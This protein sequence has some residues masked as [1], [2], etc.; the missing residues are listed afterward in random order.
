MEEFECKGIWWL[1]DDI[2]VHLYG[3]L[4]YSPEVGANLELQGSF[5]TIAESNKNNKAIKAINKDFLLRPTIILGKTVDGKFITLYKCIQTSLTQHF[6]GLAVSLFYAY[7]VF[8]GCHFSREA[9]IVFKSLSINYSNLDDW[10]RVSGFEENTV[11]DNNGQLDKIEIS[12]T[13][14]RIIEAKIDKFNITISFYLDYK[15]KMYREYH[16][17]QMT[18][19][20]MTSDA[21]VHFNNYNSEIAHH[22]QSFL[23]LAVGNAIHPNNII[24][25][26]DASITKFDDGKTVFNP[27]YIFYKLGQFSRLPIRADVL[28][29]LFFYED[30]IDNGSVN[31]YV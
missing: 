17:K 21:S 31:F 2:R 5:I 26:S 10:S 28:E 8:I 30:I 29:M 15:S 1:P 22:I 4:R 19:I 24:G 13:P 23:S 11:S 12:Y 27:I 3:T 18:I 9:D 6:P 25:N 14:P 7:Y 20:K 16:L